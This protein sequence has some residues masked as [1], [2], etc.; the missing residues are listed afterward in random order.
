[1]LCEIIL[2]KAFPNNN[3]PFGQVK[4]IVTAEKYRLLLKI[5]TYLEK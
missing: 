4:N 3:F 1:M 5:S 2:Y